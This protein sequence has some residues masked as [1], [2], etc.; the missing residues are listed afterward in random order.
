[1][2]PKN[3]NCLGEG[4]VGNKTEFLPWWECGYFLELHI[5]AYDISVEGCTG[6]SIYIIV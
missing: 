3:E 6:V 1:M 2:A 5:I 4:W